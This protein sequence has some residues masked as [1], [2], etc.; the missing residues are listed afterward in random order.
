[1]TKDRCY[2]SNHGATVI[3]GEVLDQRAREVQANLLKAVEKLA[4]DSTN[5]NGPALESM[6][7]SLTVLS[8]TARLAEKSS[9]ESSKWG[10][11]SIV[12]AVVS[13]GAA[14]CGLVM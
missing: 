2:P 8:D 12:A 14:V 13:A 10:K 4:K 3:T 5:P 1:M 6:A 7:E 9:R 11:I